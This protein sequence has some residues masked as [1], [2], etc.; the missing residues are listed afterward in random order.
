MKSIVE[1]NKYIWVMLIACLVLLILPT[2]FILFAEPEPVAIVVSDQ[3]VSAIEVKASEKK[4]LQLKEKL[5]EP[6]F[7]EK[8]PL[9]GLFDELQKS[10]DWSTYFVEDPKLSKEQNEVNRYLFMYADEKLRAAFEVLKYN[11]DR[12]DKGYSYESIKKYFGFKKK[13][14]VTKE[15]KFIQGLNIPY[16]SRLETL[17]VLDAKSR[18]DLE[19]L[20]G[21]K[22]NSKISLPHSLC[23]TSTELGRILFCDKLRKPMT[24]IVLLKKQQ[25]IVKEFATNQKLYAE[26]DKELSDLQ[27]S[28][29]AMLSLWKGYDQNSGF[30]QQFFLDERYRF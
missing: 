30:I 2:F 16:S 4:G 14:Q 29:N 13:T 10:C 20:V 12:L 26:F 23:R 6:E 1:K 24:D 19:I 15:S 7:Q 9:E 11:E 28:E 8:K 3:T 22:S 17:Q 21:P 27:L 5:Q 25:A 18:Q